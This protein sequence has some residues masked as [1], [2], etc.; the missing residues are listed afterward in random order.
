MNGPVLLTQ[1]LATRH[2][3]DALQQSWPSRLFLLSLLLRSR[4][5]QHRLPELSVAVV[6]WLPM[7]WYAMHLI[8]SS[9]TG[10]LSIYQCCKWFDVLDDLQAN[11]LVHT[12]AKKLLLCTEMA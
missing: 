5:S 7:L 3:S 9:S 11:L 2:T 10:S 1:P 6:V 12:H 8:A 4:L